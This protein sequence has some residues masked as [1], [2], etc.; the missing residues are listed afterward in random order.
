MV[1][2]VIHTPTLNVRDAVLRTVETRHDEFEVEDLG[3]DCDVAT[4]E[5]TGA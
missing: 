2:N 1:V 3:V 4:D 5:E